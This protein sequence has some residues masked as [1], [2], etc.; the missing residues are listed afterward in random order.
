MATLAQ[1][2]WIDNLAPVYSAGRSTASGVSHGFFGDPHG[3]ISTE[4][5]QQRYYIGTI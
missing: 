5:T 2:N 3:T 1:S 4:I